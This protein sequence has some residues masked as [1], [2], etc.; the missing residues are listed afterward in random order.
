VRPELAQAA[1]QG[2]IAQRQ[3]DGRDTEYASSEKSR[4]E[5]KAEAIKAAS[6]RHYG[7]VNDTYFG[8]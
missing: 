1:S 8:G 5:V 3:H 2:T 6:V 4:Q 7:D